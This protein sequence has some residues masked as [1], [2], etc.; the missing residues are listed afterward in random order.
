M[1]TRLVPDDKADTEPASSSVDPLLTV[2]VTPEPT[3]GDPDATLSR[4]PPPVTWMLLRLL[5][6][7]APVISSVPAPDLINVPESQIV[8]PNVVLVD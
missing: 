3:E 8:P 4:K 5:K 1:F 7:G 6:S 2:A